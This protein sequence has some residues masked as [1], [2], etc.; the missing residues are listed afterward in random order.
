MIFKPF[1]KTGICTCL[2][3]IYLNETCSNCNPAEG[4]TH[5]LSVATIGKSSC[6]EIFTVKHHLRLSLCMEKNTP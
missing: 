5:E 2:Q 3:Q 6:K 4:Q 1:G